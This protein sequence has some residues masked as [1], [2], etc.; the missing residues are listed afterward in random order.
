IVTSFM[1]APSPIREGP[2][3]M[4]DHTGLSVANRSVG[5]VAAG[6]R[7]RAGFVLY[8]VYALAAERRRRNSSSAPATS[9]L[10]DSTRETVAWI[11]SINARTRSSSPGVR[12][13]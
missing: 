2:P 8:V 9:V 13:P 10:A 3:S 11:R 12:S 5:R 6:L 7:D 1:A 4:E